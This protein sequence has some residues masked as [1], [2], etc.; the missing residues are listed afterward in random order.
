MHVHIHIIDPCKTKAKA[1]P[2]VIRLDGVY[3]LGHVAG[4][5]VLRFPAH[6]TQYASSNILDHTR[7]L[8]LGVG[9][10][11]S[12]CLDGPTT[13]LAGPLFRQALTSASC[14]K[15]IAA[16]PA[17]G[18][19]QLQM[20]LYHRIANGVTWAL[21]QITTEI[22]S[23]DSLHKFIKGDLGCRNIARSVYIFN[24][25]CERESQLDAAESRFQTSPCQVL[26]T[27]PGG[28]LPL[29]ALSQYPH[30]LLLSLSLSLPL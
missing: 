7:W 25:T 4:H 6:Q 3:T 22:K 19:T 15:R 29:Q 20:G 1:L 9:L 26:Q 12:L 28:P 18:T 16:S 17:I 10:L 13:C 24:R 14:A 21:M 27:G 5:D 2:Q 8:G 11:V 23:K 30:S